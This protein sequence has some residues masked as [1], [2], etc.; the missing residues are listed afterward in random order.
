MR[1]FQTHFKFSKKLFPKSRKMPE[2]PEVATFAN[3]LHDLLADC[4]ITLIEYASDFSHFKNL[5]H[6]TKKLTV[7]RVYAHGKK[8]V[9]TFK[10]GSYLLS[11]LGLEGSWFKS[12]D[13][14]ELNNLVLF[15]MKVND[16]FLYYKDTR[17]FGSIEY[18]LDYETLCQRL[19]KG[20]DILNGE[21]KI[22]D[23]QRVINEAIKRHRI[24]LQVCEFLLEQRYILG[25]GNYLRAEIIYA[26]RINP[27]K[28]V[29]ELTLNEIEQIAKFS[30]IEIQRAYE[31]R[32]ASLRTYKDFSGQE[33]NYKTRIYGH[34]ISPDGFPIQ[35]VKDRNNRTLWYCREICL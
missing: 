20:I 8:I 3:D 32:G 9:F 25:I 12:N 30:T 19:D 16:F 18:I 2:G 21:N 4:K 1:K 31:G 10:N 7:E 22:E 11:F 26:A 24:P 29:N 6:I 13:D 23:W 14:I 15:K 17:H 27:F 5:H 34:S 35:R 33:G 28:T